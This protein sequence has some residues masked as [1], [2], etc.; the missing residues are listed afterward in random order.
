MHEV[1]HTLGRPHAP[2]GDVANP[3]PEYPYAGGSI[4]SWGWDVRTGELK[5]PARYSDLL[6]YC[7][8][9]WISDHTYARIFERIRAV[10]GIAAL[11]HGEPTRYATLVVEVDGRLRW[12][13]E[14]ELVTPPPGERVP[15][16]VRTTSGVS[17]SADAV[18]V[19]VSHVPGG[20][21][22]VPLPERGEVD[23]VE[24]SGLGAIDA[25]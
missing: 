12:G 1:A 7:R 13:R 24:L 8:D 2:C 11:V 18:F 22:Y 14:L 25:P 20:I 23:R 6:G 3:D 9:T 16:T 17:A 10:R 21:V 4:G 5:S 15:A 19:A